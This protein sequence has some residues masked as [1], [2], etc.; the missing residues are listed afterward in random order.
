MQAGTERVRHGTIW[1]E[2]QVIIS[3]VY[4]IF[5]IKYAFNN[6]MY[7]HTYVF[8]C[9]SRFGGRRGYV[10]LN[11]FTYLLRG[12]RLFNAILFHIFIAYLRGNLTIYCVI[13]SFFY[14]IFFI[15]FINTYAFNNDMHYHKYIFSCLERVF[16]IHCIFTSI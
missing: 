15:F 8:S 7:Y 11:Y 10:M 1:G 4:C 9:L 3:Y 16:H 14:C 13:I 6:D 5:I 12:Q 2:T